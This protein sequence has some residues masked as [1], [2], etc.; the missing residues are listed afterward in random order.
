MTERRLKRTPQRNPSSQMREAGIVR[1]V[2]AWQI[3]CMRWTS[4]LLWSACSWLAGCGGSGTKEPDTET[5]DSLEDQ[6]EAP[7]VNLVVG[8]ICP[9]C[10]MT[11]GETS[12]FDGGQGPCVAF[13]RTLVVSDAEAAAAGFDVAAYRH[14]LVRSFQ[15]P[16]RWTDLTAT[17]ALPRATPTTGY[18]PET[19]VR[20]AVTTG[21]VTQTFFDETACDGGQACPGNTTASECRNILLDDVYQLV[22]GV[23][24]ATDDGA[25]EATL[26]GSIPLAL[27]GPPSAVETDVLSFGSH[28]DVAN[29]SGTLRI[30]P[31][32]GARRGSLDLYLGYFDDSI[33]GRLEVNFTNGWRA[34]PGTG[35]AP[36]DDQPL[37]AALQEDD[38]PFNVTPA[39]LADAHGV[40]GGQAPGDALAALRS[41][42]EQAD[43]LAAWT[44]VGETTTFDVE[45]ERAD[46]ACVTRLLDLETASHV[47]RGK[48]VK[49]PVRLTSSDGRVDWSALATYELGDAAANLPHRL[50]FEQELTPVSSRRL[51]AFPE[52]ELAAHTDR[53]FLR[54]AARYP[55]ANAETTP[56]NAPA[57]AVFEMFEQSGCPGNDLVCHQEQADSY[58]AACLVAPPGVAC[59]PLDVLDRPFF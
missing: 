53:V 2:T 14:R 15:A 46:D 28:A 10:I 36:I 30:E 9:S 8:P 11:G 40:L 17:S 41:L 5:S 44:H 32:P 23:T 57:S 34:L 39:P 3:Q 55:V 21:E 1:R 4:A 49:L 59:R 25:L 43:P 45:V 29:V 27:G 13:V 56:A 35:L 38:C 52:F 37:V 19:I 31:R 47:G 6:R 7:P 12:D 26:S 58:A 16:L 48:I 18:A 54:F 42:I 24:L 51:E 20:G 22:A 33:R 50:W